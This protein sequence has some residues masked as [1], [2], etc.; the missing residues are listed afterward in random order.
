MK[1]GFFVFEK[2]FEKAEGATFYQLMG[3]LSTRSELR[4][5]LNARLKDGL[6]AEDFFIIRGRE[7]RITATKIVAEFETAEN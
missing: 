1:P 2:T 7:E 5:Y 6:K 4:K 3:N